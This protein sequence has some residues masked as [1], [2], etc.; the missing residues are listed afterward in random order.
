MKFAWIGLAAA[1]TLGF[2]Q[3]NA[4]VLF[5]GTTD[6]CFGAT[7][8]TA[9]TNPSDGKLSFA[10]GSF[11]SVPAGTVTLGSFSLHNGSGNFNE[12]FELF[13]TFTVPSGTSSGQ[14]FTASVL[15]SVSGNSGS[16]AI[17][18]N[19]TPQTFSFNGGTFTLSITDPAAVTTRVDS[20]SLTGNIVL[21]AVPELSTWAMMI[22]GFLG[23]G[24]MAHRRKNQMAA[25]VSAA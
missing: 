5:S 1:L 19:N 22:L 13:V 25:A 17:D 12:N 15:G 4:V 2:G 14:P 8:C 24:F 6:G 11:S 7:T 23:L 10:D 18:F 3:A 20:V 16:V 9:T 21:A